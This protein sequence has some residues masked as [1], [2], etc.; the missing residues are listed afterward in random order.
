MCKTCVNLGIIIIFR[1][2]IKVL[3][4][5]TGENLSDFGLGGDYFST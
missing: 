1:T 4:Y 3:E 5:T 2:I